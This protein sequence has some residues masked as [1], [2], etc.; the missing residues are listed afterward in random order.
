M[1][2]E[3]N[4]KSIEH[5]SGLFYGNNL[6]TLVNHVVH[7]RGGVSSFRPSPFLSKQFLTPDQILN[8]MGRLIEPFLRIFGEW[9]PA[10][11]VFPLLS[12]K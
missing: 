1:K 6:G 3:M 7:G 11:Q 9:K 10:L 8:G 2:G 5:V 12:K 4:V